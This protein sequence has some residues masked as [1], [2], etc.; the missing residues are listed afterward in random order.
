VPSLLQ[1]ATVVC[2]PSWGEGVPKVLLEAAAAGR[3]IVTTDAPGCREVVRDG[4]EGLVVPPRDAGALA[5]AIERALRL[6]DAE[7]AAMGAR[8]RARIARDFSDARVVADTLRVY[9]ELMASRQGG[10]VRRALF[11]L[12]AIAR[13]H[14]YRSTRVARVLW[15]ARVEPEGDISVWELGTLALARAL[16][17][18][19]KDGL[20][21]LELGTGP[22]AVLSLWA[23]SRWRLALTATEID[24][25]WAEAARR[26]VAANRA[27]VDVRCADLFDGLHERYDVVWFVPPFTPAATVDRQIADPRARVR[28]CGGEHGWEVIDR[29]LAGV[30]AHLAPGGR[31]C[32]V[33]SRVHQPLDTIR[34]LIHKRG[35][36]VVREHRMTPLPYV[37]FVVTTAILRASQPAP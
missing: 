19:L 3:A 8:A 20:R 4:I 26:A 6:S 33:V 28:T 1:R 18:E 36:R 2:V 32:F 27:R 37:T 9:D 22:Y 17:R 16:R 7:R 29:F 25:A 31:A 24:P 12:N 23:A 21:A 5:A 34:A 13:A 10:V 14:V 35:L 30:G 15:N 11:A